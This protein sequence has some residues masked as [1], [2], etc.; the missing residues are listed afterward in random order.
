MDGLHCRIVCMIDTVWYV[1]GGATGKAPPPQC[2]KDRV[3]Y[4]LKGRVESNQRIAVEGQGTVEERR[5]R[6]AVSKTGP[7]FSRAGVAA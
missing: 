2:P 1:G 4:V 7:T 5:G 6:G 3:R